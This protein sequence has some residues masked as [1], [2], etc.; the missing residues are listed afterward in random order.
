MRSANFSQDTPQK[1]ASLPKSR[2][3]NTE[4]NDSTYDLH[5]SLASQNHIMKDSLTGSETYNDNVYTFK[6]P[7]NTLCQFR[8]FLIDNMDVPT[9]PL[10][11]YQIQGG[12]SASWSAESPGKTIMGRSDSASSDD[13]YVPMNPVQGPITLTHLATHPQPFLFIKAPA[14]KVRSSHSQSI[15]TSSLTEKQSQ[16]PWT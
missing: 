9:T 11:A 10:S 13:N 15:T 12:E 5:H 6:T 16:H 8:D 4:F 3:H 2:R 14:E 1:N 7:N